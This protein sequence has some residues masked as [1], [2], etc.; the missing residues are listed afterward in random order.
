MTTFAATVAI[1]TLSAGI[2]VPLFL[3]TTLIGR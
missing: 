2:L 1:A 3:F